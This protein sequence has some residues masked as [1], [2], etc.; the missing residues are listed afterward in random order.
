MSTPYSVHP[1]FEVVIGLEV[2]V[3]LATESKIF[4]PARARHTGESVADVDVNSSVSPVCAGHP[5]TLPVLNKKVVDYAIA[6]GL[7]TQCQIKKKNVFAR[8]HYFYPDLPKGYQISQYD[9]PIC[10][11][12]HLDINL[13]DG[14]QKRV[15]IQRIHM[16][17]D[18]GKN[19][20]LESF[21]LVNLNRAGVPLIEI[22]SGADMKTPEEAGAYL[23]ALYAI[24]TYLGIC[25][26]NLQ[27]GNFRCDANVSV[28]RKGSKEWGTRTET[29]NVNSFR[30]VEKAIE[31]EARRQVD[32]ILAGGK[33]VQETRTY[34]PDQDKTISMRSKEEAHDYRYFPDPDLMP[35]IL[36][37]AWIERIR[38]SL[39]ELPEQKRGRYVTDLGLTPYDAGVLTA[40]KE[41]ASFFEAA[42]VTPSAKGQ[43]SKKFAKS[44]SNL[45]AGEVSRLVNETQTPI[46]LSK[47]T[48][49]AIARISELLLTNI[50]S[51]TGA[52]TIIVQT[53]SHGDSVDAIVDREG[54]KQVSDLS[55]LD[56]VIEQVLAANA[57]QVAQFRAG[58]DKLIGFFVG[59]VMKATGGKANPALL[60]D[61][62]LRKLKS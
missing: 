40:S 2:H 7:A 13:S 19:V 45:L 39:P 35:L 37:D 56:P 34:D 46:E 22:V 28:M 5:G 49:Q 55:A 59:Q 1:E 3:Q 31:Y 36:D 26:G 8:K 20:H 30:Y 53:W 24:V 10:E 6:A 44:V 42:M 21:S 62:I 17:E 14:S 15:N 25:D 47:L 18:A 57:D 9:L 52:K 61:A 50:I 41:L 43:D 32:V 12:G 54:L 33:I 16:E 51:S 29:K 60:Q 38:A 48:P 27:E 4:S 58:K 23:R 11:H